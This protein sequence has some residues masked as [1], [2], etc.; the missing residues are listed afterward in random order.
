MAEPFLTMELADEAATEAFAEDVAACVRQGD[1]IALYGDLG[2]G[3]TT[4]A[5]AFIRAL[6][7]DLALE[8]PSPTFTLV[9]SYATE[10]ATLA[11]VDLYRIRDATEVEEA[12]LFDAGDIFVVEWP[13][14]ASALLPAERLEVRLEIAGTARRARVSGTQDWQGRLDRSRGARAFLD[15]S[16]FGGAHRVPLGPRVSTAPGREGIV[17]AG[18]GPAVLLDWPPRGHGRDH[19]RNAAHV[20]AWT[21]VNNGLREA[22]L[23]A[24]G[25]YAVDPAKGFALGEDLGTERLNDQRGQ[26]IPERY[27]VAI[28]ALAE[29]HVKPRPTALATTAAYISSPILPATCWRETSPASPM[30]TCPMRPANRC[31]PR[32]ERNSTACGGRTSNAWWKP[33]A[34]GCCK[35]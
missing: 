15:R 17:A 34:H 24:P 25:T 6:S 13:E 22:G 7:R 19:G 27:F 11:H 33:N 32:S 4:F 31:R 14:R 30:T 18:R 5:R 9:Q 1:T 28:E 23:S 35:R 21:A 20:S 12:G 2:A 8:V 10:R 16:G 29:I 26:P 3:K